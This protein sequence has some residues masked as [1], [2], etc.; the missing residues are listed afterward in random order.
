MKKYLACSESC[1]NSPHLVIGN[2][3]RMVLRQLDVQ[4]T[5]LHGVLEEEVYM[6][7]P[8][9][10]EDASKPGYLCKLDK[11]LYRLKQAPRASI[12]I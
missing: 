4:N 5:F 7:Q 6:R 2:V 3:T 12:L 8:S 10:Y 11:A 9:G 1:H